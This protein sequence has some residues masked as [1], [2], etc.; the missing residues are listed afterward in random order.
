MFYIQFLSAYSDLFLSPPPPPVIKSNLSLPT[1]AHPQIPPAEKFK[2]QKNSQKNF[3][4]N[5]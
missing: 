4:E 1:T 2:T 3:H 5:P